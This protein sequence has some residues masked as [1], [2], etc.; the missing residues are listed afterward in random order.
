MQLSAPIVS[1]NVGMPQTIVD[2]GKEIQTGIYKT[3]VKEPVYLSAVNFTGDGQADLVYHGGPDKAV[4]VY[5]YRHY[6]YWQQALNR[7]LSCGAFGEN[8]TMDGLVETEVCIGDVF[9][10]GEALVQ[11]SQPRQP[12]HKLAKRYGVDDLPLRVRNT[13][14]TGFYFRVLREGMVSCD[15]PIRLVERNPQQ[16]TVA[17]ANQI[18]YHDQHNAEAIKR[19]LNV[20]ALSASWRDT[21]LKRLAGAEAKAGKRLKTE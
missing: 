10:L 5:S 11:V 14:Y 16:V 2:K 4:C 13:G 18:M 19:I 6:P 17:F 3:P 1:I 21:L 20:E 15:Q 8:L 7:P 12:C 9:Q